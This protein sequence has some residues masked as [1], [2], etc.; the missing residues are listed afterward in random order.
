M[1]RQCPVGLSLLLIDKHKVIQHILSRILSDRSGLRSDRP[2][3]IQREHD[4]IARR[5]RFDG[6]IEHTEGPLENPRIVPDTVISD[7]IPV[8]VIDLVSDD[9]VCDLSVPVMPVV[10]ARKE[11]RHRLHQLEAILGF[12]IEA[13]VQ[14]RIARDHLRARTVERRLRRIP[15][16][17]EVYRDRHPCA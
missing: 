10:A 4:I 6:G 3:L 17:Y 12:D 13:I 2:V 7:I 5:N 9:P 8:L 11:G 1:D 16:I 14:R 15:S